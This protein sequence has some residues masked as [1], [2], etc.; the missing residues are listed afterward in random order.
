[1]E[2]EIIKSIR[3]KFIEKRHEIISCSKP[4]PPWALVALLDIDDSK[5]SL[6]AE[7]LL[8]EAL[9]GE[10]R[11]GITIKDEVIQVSELL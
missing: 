9:A 6:P 8:K 7:L 3:A 2:N 11:M 5:T 10:T 4:W 1:M